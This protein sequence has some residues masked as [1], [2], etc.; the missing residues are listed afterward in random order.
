MSVARE[1]SERTQSRVL[2]LRLEEAAAALSMS[3]EA[4]NE[5][6]RPEVR[7]VSCGRMRLVAIAELERWLDEN[8]AYAIE[9]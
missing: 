2:A 9:P 4:F 1:L 7:V 6:V 8:A 5:H 3:V